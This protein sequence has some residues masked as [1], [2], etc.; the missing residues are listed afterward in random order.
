M[1]LSDCVQYILDSAGKPAYVVL[2]VD[3][4]SKIEASVAPLLKEQPSSPTLVQSSGPLQSF[5]EF[6]QCW[7]F[8]YAYDP[9]VHCP[10][11]GVETS[12]WRNDPNS[13]FV[14]TN[15]N[16]GGLLVF[17]CRRCGTTI[18]QKHFRDHVALE[19]ST[20]KA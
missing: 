13:P 9:A 2:P 12:D 17:H 11:C 7:D 16:I 15:A 5:E 19:H 14:L 6:M 10:H 20:P 8:R 3:V 18:R 1:S 4:W